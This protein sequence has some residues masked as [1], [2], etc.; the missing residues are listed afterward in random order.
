VVVK[1]V[2]DGRVL[3]GDPAKGSVALSRV[4]FEAIWKNRFLFVIHN[5]MESAKF[6]V[7]S[8]WRIAPR[9]PLAAGVNRDGVANVTIPRMGPGEF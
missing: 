9:A 5:R 7:A 2:K 1:G 3:L 8:D 4:A 6:N